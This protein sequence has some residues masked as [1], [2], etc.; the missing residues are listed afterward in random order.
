MK[1]LHV[2]PSYEPAWAFGGTVTATSNLCRALAWQGTDVTVYT[3]DADG[4]GGHLNVPLNQPIDLGGVKV[5]Y[6][7][8]DFGVKKAFYSRGLARKLKETVKNFDLVHVSAIWQWTQLNVFKNCMK[9]NIPYIVSPHS[10][11]MEWSFEE[12]GNKLLKKLFWESFSSRT[13]SMATAIHFLCEGERITSKKYIG[14]SSSFIVP[15]GI[16]LDIFKFNEQKRNEMREKFRIS[17]ETIVLLYLGRIHRKKNIELIMEALRNQNTTQKVILF[18]IGHIEDN[19]Y[20]QLLKRTASNLNVDSSIRW[21]PPVESREV[22]DFYFMSDLM[23]LPSKSEGISMAI[24]EALG[25]SLPVLISNRVA[26]YREIEMDKAGIVVKPT[27][28]SVVEAIKRILSS[29][30]LLKTFSQNARKSAESRYA[31]DKVAYLMIKAY[32]DVLTG[33][34]SPELQWR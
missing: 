4:K 2:I 3:T 24:T 18:I 10:S 32:E 28:E 22:K 7:H 12:V 19:T 5:W 9:N 11:L 13:I 26:N 29:P 1:V 16:I 21:L 34:R 25:A 15:N 31:L 6:F 27:Q 8:C 14:N 17:N 23:M 33:R 30:S 20:Y